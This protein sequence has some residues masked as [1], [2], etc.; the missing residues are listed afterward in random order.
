MGAGDGIKVIAIDYAPNI[1]VLRKNLPNAEIIEF[2]LE[3]GVPQI[4]EDILKNAVVMSSDVIEHI[5]EPH[6]YL[7]ALARISKIAPYV[8]VSTPDRTRARG[9]ENFGPPDNPFHVR[10]WTIDEL[11]SLFKQYHIECKI[12]HTVSNDH[13]NFKG[14]TLA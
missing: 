13:D 12:G 14:T 5:V 9:P 2:D 3:K 11:Y 1:K 6:K 7:K 10:E 4:S 8:L